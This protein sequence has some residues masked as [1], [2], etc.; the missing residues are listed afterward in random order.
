MKPPFFN[1]DAHISIGAFVAVRS[2]GRIS[3]REVKMFGNGQPRCHPSP[4]IALCVHVCTCR[5]GNRL[6]E[7]RLSRTES[8]PQPVKQRQLEQPE[9]N[10]NPSSQPQETHSSASITSCGPP[11]FLSSSRGGTSG[12]SVTPDFS[13]ND[14]GIRKESQ[15]KSILLLE[16]PQLYLYSVDMRTDLPA[17]SL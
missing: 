14:E 4:R 11:F 13:P 12:G 15:T 16:P 2:R 3:H 5:H 8:H 10:H 6:A 7:P 17:K 9:T 1:I